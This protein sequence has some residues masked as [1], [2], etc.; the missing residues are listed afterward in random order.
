MRGLITSLDI[1]II[2]SF[3][4]RGEALAQALRGRKEQN[5]P[6]RTWVWN[7]ASYTDMLL[8][9]N[10]SLCNKVTCTCD[11]HMLTDHMFTKQPGTPDRCTW[12]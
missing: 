5:T 3:M 1:P 9:Y 2:A 4:S 8:E 6:I 12:G 7:D 10:C 11:Q